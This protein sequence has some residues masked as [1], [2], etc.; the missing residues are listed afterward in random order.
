M[1]PMLRVQLVVRGKAGATKFLGISFA[2]TRR[3]EIPATEP[4]RRL[5]RQEAAK[6]NLVLQRLRNSSV[7]HVSWV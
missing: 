3:F 1:L 4:A 5:I 7:I 2:D 6:L